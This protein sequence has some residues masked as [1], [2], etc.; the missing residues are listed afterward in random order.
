M[1]KKKIVRNVVIISIIVVII[2]ILIFS[3]AMFFNTSNSDNSTKLGNLDVEYID[4]E[5]VTVDNLLPINNDEVEEKAS[6]F[7][8]SVENKGNSYAYYDIKLVDIDLPTALTDLNFKWRLMKD[9]EIINEGNFLEIQN[10]KYYLKRSIGIDSKDTNN[11]KLQIWIENSNDIDQNYILNRN[12]SFKIQIEARQ[13]LASSPKDQITVISNTTNGALEDLKIYGNSIDGK[14][15]G[16]NKT[17]NIT[18]SQNLVDN[19]LGEAGNNSNFSKFTY[20][21]EKYKSLG[22]FTTSG[23]NININNY[24]SINIENNYILNMC[25]KSIGEINKVYA[26]IY[27]YDIDKNLISIENANYYRNTLT[28]LTQDLKNGDE[29]IYLNDTSNFADV[30][31]GYGLIFWN[32]IDTRGYTY[33]ENTYS[34]NVWT[35]L[36]KYDNI[37]KNNNIIKLNE[38]WNH[39]KIKKGTKVSRSKVSGTYNYGLMNTSFNDTWT[40]YE[41]IMTNTGVESVNRFRYG[42]KYIQW[43]TLNNYNKL[44]NTNDYY[45]R[46]IIRETKN[47]QNITIDMTDHDPLRS[48]DDTRDY[49]DYKNKRIVRLINNDGSIKTKPEYEPINLPEIKTYGGNTIIESSDEVSPLFQAYY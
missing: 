49:I 36:F 30:P 48:I 41:N 22:S 2:G 28:F 38:P 35:S 19:G 33:S 11:Y 14:N 40:C 4:G 44:Q 34:R 46:I 5:E 24:I 23:G 6:V 21:D 32:Y 31:Y 42:A 13:K 8:F 43:M 7:N 20:S 29:Y 18:V 17:I 47:I 25:G 26:G 37:N 10:T 1:D 9:N 39:G 15:V 16:D 3:Y 12:G 45:S 27:E